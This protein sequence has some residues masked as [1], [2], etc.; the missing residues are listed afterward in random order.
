MSNIN[1]INNTNDFVIISK[2]WKK[3]DVALTEFNSIFLHNIALTTEYASSSRIKLIC[4]HSG[5]YR[6][7]RKAKKVAS[8][9]SVMGE[10]LPE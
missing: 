6:D 1:N 10:T 4:K 7:T 9:T 5:K 3:Y 2:M 8:E